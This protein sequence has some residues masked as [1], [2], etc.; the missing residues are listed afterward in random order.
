MSTEDG[1][2]VCGLH[3]L[4]CSRCGGCH[5][6][7]REDGDVVTCKG[8]NAFREAVAAIFSDVKNDT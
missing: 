5:A 7:L 3:G 8:P 4:A 1:E 6:C 2:E